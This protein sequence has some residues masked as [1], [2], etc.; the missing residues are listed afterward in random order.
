MLALSKQSTTFASAIQR[1]ENVLIDVCQHVDERVSTCL[2]KLQRLT[3]ATKYH[4]LS[5]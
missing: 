1:L 5:Y 2:T 3:G 4:T